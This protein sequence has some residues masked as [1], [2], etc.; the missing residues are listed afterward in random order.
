M[1]FYHNSSNHGFKSGLRWSFQK[2]TVIA[3]SLICYYTLHCVCIPLGRHCGFFGGFL[4]FLQILY[5]FSLL[6]DLCM[7]TTISSFWLF[8]FLHVHICTCAQFACGIFKPQLK[9]FFIL[10]FYSKAPIVFPRTEQIKNI[11]N[12]SLLGMLTNGY[13]LPFL[14]SCEPVLIPLWSIKKEVLQVYDLTEEKI[15]LLFSGMTCSFL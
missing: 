2:M 7:W 5:I 6:P 1:W 11:F 13:I 4:H 3:A 10:N 14:F 8:D 9:Y 12:F 15:F